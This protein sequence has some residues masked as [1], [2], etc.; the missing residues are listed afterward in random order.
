MVH[1]AVA[2]AVEV[3]ARRVVVARLGTPGCAARA[4]GSLKGYYA[5]AP[6]E[7]SVGWDCAQVEGS[8]GTSCLV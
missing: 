6:E 2:V 8:L 5:A 1:D 4:E 7:S 3:T